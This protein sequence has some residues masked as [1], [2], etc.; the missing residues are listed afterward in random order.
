MSALEILLSREGEPVDAAVF[1]ESAKTV[2]DLVQQIERSLGRT[3]VATRW[4]I[5]E[6]RLGSAVVVTTPIED[7]P[8]AN[9]A[10]E[11]LVKGVG[12]LERSPQMPSAFT[13]EV[14][15]GLLRVASNSEQSDRARLTLRFG[16]GKAAAAAAVSAQLAANARKLLSARI[17]EFESVQGE[18]DRIDVRGGKREVSIFDTEQNRSVRATFSDDMLADIVGSIKQ[19]VAAW[20][21]AQK[22]ASGQI[23]SFE[24]ERLERIDDRPPVSVREIAGIAPWWTDGE[25]PTEWVRRHR[26]EE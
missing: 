8:S 23:V 2:I 9:E 1:F 18:I 7:S 17:L 3:R 5:T 4:G 6:L 19:R 15:R 22:T 26:E 10:G 12:S 25:D 21:L 24:I 20:G 14:L 13:L 16:E 11:L